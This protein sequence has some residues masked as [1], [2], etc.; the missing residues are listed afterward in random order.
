MSKDIIVVGSGL[1]GMACASYLAKNNHSVTVIEKNST[2]GGRLQSIS[3]NGYTF[4]SGPSWYWMPDI[5]DSFFADFGKST[6]DFYDLKRIN[7]GYRVYFGD[8]DTFDL[9]EDLILLKNRL[10]DLEEGAGDSL[11][12]YL[13]DAKEKYN[14]AVQKFMYK[15]SLSP[16]EYI[17][18]DLI[19]SLIH[20]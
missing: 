20:I 6:S 12:K 15:P 16:L 18:S 9:E 5:F 4:D 1:A 17:K 11:Q 14:V 19:L 13:D 2:Y 10:D 8:D 7:P 3:K